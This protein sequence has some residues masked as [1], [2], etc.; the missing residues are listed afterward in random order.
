[1]LTSKLL[2]G[3]WKALCACRVLQGLTQ[4]GLYP[5]LQTLISSWVPVSERGSFSGYIY[6]G[7]LFIIS[8]VFHSLTPLEAKYID[9]NHCDKKTLKHEGH[10]MN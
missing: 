10:F 7:T 9:K 6:T 1:M 2:Q 8:F 3:G 5:A 4:A